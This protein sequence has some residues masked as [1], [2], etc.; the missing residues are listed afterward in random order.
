MSNTEPAIRAYQFNRSRRIYLETLGCAKNRVDTEIMITALLGTGYELTADPAQAQVIIVNTCA[1]LTAATEEGIARLLDLSDY[2]SGGVCEKLVCAGC[3]SERYREDLLKEVPEIDGLLGSSNFQEIPALLDELYAA[4][5]EGAGE[6]GEAGARSAGQVVRLLPKPH[7]AHYETH[8]RVLTTPGAY[9]YLKIAEGCSNMCSFCNIPFLR[10]YFS[11]RKIESV[12]GEARELIAAG[13]REINIISQDISSYGADFRD[14][15]RLAH[16]LRALDNL[17]GDY[18]LRLFYA[19]PNTFGEE[20][21]E[22]LAGGRHLAPYLDMPFQ[23]ISARVL[24]DMNRRIT[25]REIR[26]RVTRLKELLP[27]LALRT[28]FIVGFPTETEEDFAELLEFVREGWFEHVG[29]FAYSHE[30]NIRSARLGDPVPARVKR[31]RRKALLEAQQEIA[32]ARNAARV[33]QVFRVLVEGPSAETDLLLQGRA[34]FQGPEV[35]GVVYINE[36]T[37]QSGQFNQVEITD[38]NVYDLIGRIV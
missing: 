28:T 31:Q 25:G 30:D 17:E 32:S 6:A 3:L 34:E 19:Y 23:H 12:V 20:E 4:G 14:G 26:G 8:S 38:S 16:L 15:T 24:Q 21:M 7:Y 22:A 37:A 18:W 9:A 33:G 10:G 2:K 11:S 27:R 5:E 35:D 13:V 36:G 1:F 29:V